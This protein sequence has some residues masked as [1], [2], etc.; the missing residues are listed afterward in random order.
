MINILFL[1]RKRHLTLAFFLSLE[2][3]P[4]VNLR[5]LVLTHPPPPP[6]SIRV[7]VITVALRYV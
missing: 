5:V 4:F 3:S 2:D 6:P 1:Y 7:H